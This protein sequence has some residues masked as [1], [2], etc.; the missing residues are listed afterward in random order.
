MLLDAEL[1]SRWSRLTADRNPLHVDDEYARS[2]RFGR[3]IVQGHLIAAVGL[4]ALAEAGFDRGTVTFTFHEPIPVGTEVT[5]CTT[6]D[7][8]EIR[9]LGGRPVDVVVVPA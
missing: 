5:I 7:G 4:D 3:T 2:T 8:M 1:V 6:L 9:A